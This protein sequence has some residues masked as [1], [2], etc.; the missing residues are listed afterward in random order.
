[1]YNIT[2][3]SKENLS[4]R[5]FIG[6]VSAFTGLAAGDCLGLPAADGRTYSVAVLGDLHYD[7]APDT[8][9]HAKFIELFRAAKK[10][11]ARF[12]EFVRNAKMWAGPSRRLLAASGACATGDT[13]LVLQMGDLIQ[14]DCNDFT[15][16]RRMLDETAA[17]MKAAYPSRLPFVTTCGNHDVREGGKGRDLA[18]TPVYSEFARDFHCKELGS[19]VRGAIDASTFA[20]RQGPDL[21][22]ALDFNCA[23]DHVPLVKKILE[24]NKGVRHTFVLSHGGVFPFDCWGCRWFYLGGVSE[25]HKGMKPHKDADRLRREMRAL[26]AARNAIVLCG[27][28][29]HL[30]LKDAKFPEGTITEVTM[31][32]VPCQSKGPDLPGEPQ[33]VREGAAAYGATDW[34]KKDPPIAALFDEYRPYM[35]RYYLANAAGHA[36]LRVSDEGVWF[37]YYGRA[38][39]SPTK[40][41]RLR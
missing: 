25:S 12:K 30:E 38:A 7:T 2:V 9:Y 26:L 19:R 5:E 18:A 28:T 17:R 11:P 16:H 4:R 20:F 13:A 29:H 3:M 27:H 14:G 33:V 24:A 36:R 39:V 35:T 6:G 32:S 8:V 1:M 37:D 22:V 40:T 21:Y 31:N 15:V 34:V 41:F 10:H 23:I